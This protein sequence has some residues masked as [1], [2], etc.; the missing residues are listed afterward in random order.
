[1]LYIGIDLSQNSTG[2]A[3]LY[4]W[5]TKILKSATIKTLKFTPENFDE[6]LKIFYEGIIGYLVKN[7]IK[8]NTLKVGIELSNFGNANFTNKVHFYAGALYVMLKKYNPFVEIKFYN[9]NA[10][11]NKL[12]ETQNIFMNMPNIETDLRKT[13]AWDF[14]TKKYKC[15][16]GSF[17][18][19]DAI[20]IA[21]Y[22]DECLNSI[23][24]NEFN[25]T[26]KKAAKLKKVSKQKKI[27]KLK[28][29]EIALKAKISDY[30]C[31][32]KLK[33]LTKPQTNKL[34]N[35]KIELAQIQ[36]EIDEISTKH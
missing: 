21:H 19:S 7:D 3:F 30:E 22:F 26:L 18:E 27:L 29:K 24:L 8:Y 14:A 16:V 28:E 13:I 31:K 23:E 2:V 9:A 17:D 25:K 6:N 35:L 36:G 32:S 12:L 34:N 20:C 33:T 1:M 11:F 15:D 5:E 4:K 10:W